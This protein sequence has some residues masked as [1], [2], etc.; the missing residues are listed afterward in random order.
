MWSVLTY[1]FAEA[2]HSLEY[3]FAVVGQAEEHA[4]FWKIERGVPE[5]QEK[6]QH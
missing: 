6:L 1:F 3:E 4:E 5:S 2:C